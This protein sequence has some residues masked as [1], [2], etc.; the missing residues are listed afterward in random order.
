MCDI[1]YALEDLREK[2]P[3]Y[4]QNM[5]SFFEDEE[6]LVVD[7]IY[8]RLY[9]SYP[10]DYRGIFS[11]WHGRLNDLFKFMN[12]KAE[13]NGHYNANESHELLELIK[14]IGELRSVLSKKG[15][16]FRLAEI[17]DDKLKEVSGFLQQTCGSVIPDTYHPMQVEK[18]SPIFFINDDNLPKIIDDLGK[19]FNDDYLRT[20]LNQMYS[21][22]ESNPAD[23]IGKAKS[24][25]TVERNEVCTHGVQPLCRRI[26]RQLANARPPRE[27]D[28]LSVRRNPPQ[29][30][31]PRLRHALLDLREINAPCD[32]IC[33]TETEA[34]FQ[35][36]LKLLIAV[37]LNGD[38]DNACRNR[39]LEIFTH[40]RTIN[41]ETLRDLALLQ[42][43][44][45]VKICRFDKDPFI[46]GLHV[47]SSSEKCFSHM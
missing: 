12:Q 23:A 9:E 31:Q 18:Y 19:E 6:T 17:Y 11:V 37:R 15:I 24:R 33:L 5:F 34:A 26:M 20:Q 2:Y 43:I 36:T 30:T 35:R 13:S 8:L 7:K 14:S 25:S 10:E 39:T 46:N 45:I 29:E 42:T 22:I 41:A 16:E 3:L 1:K 28:G 40:C 21:T 47:T 4:R 44:R 27:S 38:A 32:N